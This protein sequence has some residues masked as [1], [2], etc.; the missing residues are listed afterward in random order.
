[1]FLNPL[2]FRSAWFS[3]LSGF[4]YTST[5][6][7]FEMATSLAT[8]CFSSMVVFTFCQLVFSGVTGMLKKNCHPTMMANIRMYAQ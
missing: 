5:S 3:I 1:M 7:V 4:R 2:A 6:P 8:S